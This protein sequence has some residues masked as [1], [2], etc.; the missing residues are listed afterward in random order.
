MGLADAHRTGV[1][2]RIG[3]SCGFG[4]SSITNLVLKPSTNK[5]L[6]SPGVAQPSTTLEEFVKPLKEGRLGLVLVER[7]GVG[8]W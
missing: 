7:C 8:V 5:D 1:R 2:L 4:A 6:L 3:G